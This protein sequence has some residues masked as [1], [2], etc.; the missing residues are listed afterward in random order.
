MT[1]PLEQRVARLEAD[2]YRPDSGLHASVQHLTGAI[3]ELSQQQRAL[4]FDV[5]EIR[6]TVS[7]LRR[8]AVG[9]DLALGKILDHFGLTAATGSEIDAA[10]DES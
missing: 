7:A 8:H 3:G 9:T 2:L 5:R 6:Q 4:A 10:L 1:T